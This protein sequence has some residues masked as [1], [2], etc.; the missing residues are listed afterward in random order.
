MAKPTR[1]NRGAKQSC[2]P[3]SSHHLQIWII[4]DLD[5]TKAGGG[6][7]TPIIMQKPF[8]FLSHKRDCSTLLS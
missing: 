3:K 1:Q 6:A 8:S 7:E 5:Y 2:R 4:P